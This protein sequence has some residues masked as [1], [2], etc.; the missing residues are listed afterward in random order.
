MKYSFNV[1]FEC[2]K[3]HIEGYKF[4]E[5]RQKTAVVN[6]QNAIRKALFFLNNKHDLGLRVNREST[7]GFDALL[8]TERAEILTI[9]NELL[10]IKNASKK[11]KPP[12][13]IIKI[14][15][16]LSDLNIERLRLRNAVLGIN[17][18]IFRLE[19]YLKTY[20]GIL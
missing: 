14:E 1:C 4:T 17:D 15:T 7:T 20:F 8:S 3:L 19:K 12:P 13:D 9:I 5:I 16:L 2:L 18:K 11:K 10:A 6:P